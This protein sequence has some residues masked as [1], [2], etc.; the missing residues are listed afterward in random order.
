MQ[1]D[2]HGRTLQV[3]EKTD[4]STTQPPPDSRSTSLHRVRRPSGIRMESG[5]VNRFLR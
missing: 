4:V 3:H 1:T 5:L 2:G